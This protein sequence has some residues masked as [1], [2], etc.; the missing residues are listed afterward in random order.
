MSLN[1][2]PTPASIANAL[3]KRNTPQ[4]KNNEFTMIMANVKVSAHG[5]FRSP[6]L[7][8]EER[9]EKKE[10]RQHRPKT[11]KQQ[12]PHDPNHHHHHHHNTY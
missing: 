8:R 7:E 9:R 12:R 10:E 11:N 4:N 6:R 5:L 2:L 1:L 3:N